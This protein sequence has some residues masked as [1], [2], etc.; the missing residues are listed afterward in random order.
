MHT[1]SLVTGSFVTQALPLCAPPWPPRLEPCGPQDAHVLLV[2]LF[3]LFLSPRCLPH[4]VRL[5]DNLLRFS[6]NGASSMKPFPTA[7]HFHPLEYWPLP[8]LGFSVAGTP[9]Y[10]LVCYC[11][12]GWGPD[13]IL[14]GVLVLCGCLWPDFFM[15]P[16]EG[17]SPSL[18]GVGDNNWVWR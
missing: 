18:S 3:K 2:S 17:V 1:F 9:R 10:D 13:L 11:G 8:S 12:W 16:G 4:T 7:S 15:P 14:L 5:A 6:W